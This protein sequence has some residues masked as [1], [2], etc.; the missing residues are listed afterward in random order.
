MKAKDGAPRVG[1]GGREIARTSVRHCRSL[2]AAGTA[3]A[4]VHTTRVHVLLLDGTGEDLI[5]HLEVAR[6]PDVVTRV[7]A[8]LRG[9]GE[10]GDHTALVQDLLV[11][12]AQ[13]GLCFSRLAPRAMPVEHDGALLAGH[14]LTDPELHLLPHHRDGTGS[15][16]R[17]LSGLGRNARRT[18]GRRLER[19]AV[20]VAV[21]VAVTIAIVRRHH[22]CCR[23]C[24]RRRR[25]HRRRCCRHRPCRRGPCLLRRDHCKARPWARWSITAAADDGSSEHRSGEQGSKRALGR[26]NGKDAKRAGQR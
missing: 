6:V 1:H 22:R 2:Q 4:G 14:L 20:A 7:L 21:A 16:G 10:R 11:A 8:G 25:R 5:G 26:T 9:G 17:T 3:A 19:I 23:P 12:G 15:N 18:F 24:R 13:R